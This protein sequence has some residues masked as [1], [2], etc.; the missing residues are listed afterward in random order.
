MTS[1]CSL[2]SLPAAPRFV[3]GLLLATASP[4]AAAEPAEVAGDDPFSGTYEVKG[5]TTDLKSG[6]TRR[7]VGHIVLTKQGDHWTA[8]SDLTTDFP[9]QG[10]AVHTDVIGNGEGTR[11]GDGLD[12]TAHTQLVIGMV[13]GVDAGFAFVPRQVG[14]RIV[15]KWSAHRDKD[16]SLVIELSNAPEKGEQYTPT[17]TTLRGTRVEMPAEASRN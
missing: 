5:M 7:I 11:K 1:R 13:P 2:H 16:G 3:L 15:S 14:P 4:A 10:G 6:D 9:T 12:G 17:K 8:K